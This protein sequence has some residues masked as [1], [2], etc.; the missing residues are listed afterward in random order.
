MISSMAKVVHRLQIYLPRRTHT[1]VLAWVCRVP[2]VRGFIVLE[3]V[4]D[5]PDVSGKFNV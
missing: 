5:S 3:A 4:C 1:F 2:G